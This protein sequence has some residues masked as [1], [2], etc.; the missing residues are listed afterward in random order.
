M[1]EQGIAQEMVSIALRHAEAN[2]AQRVIQLDIEMSELADE[3]EESL[4]FYLDLVT[5]TTIAQAARFNILHVP[6]HAHCRDC[7]NDFEQRELVSLCP[8]CGGM[9]TTVSHV[10]EFKLLSIQID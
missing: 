3:T 2:H 7:D 4:R 8:R 1:H 9:N 5:Q 10:D 6:V